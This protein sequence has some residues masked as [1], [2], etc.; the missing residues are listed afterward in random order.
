MV[1]KHRPEVKCNPWRRGRQRQDLV[2]S[3]KDKEDMLAML[4]MSISPRWIVLVNYK[5]SCIRCVCV[6]SAAK[7]AERVT[8]Q[9]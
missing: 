4:D 7:T 6:Q 2:L 5:L 9:S 3:R 1:I 8:S